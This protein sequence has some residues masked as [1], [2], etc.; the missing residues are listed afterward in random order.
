MARAVGS[1]ST[2]Q[3]F[4]SPILHSFSIYRAGIAVL[5]L[6]L[7]VAACRPAHERPVDLDEFEEHD[8][9]SYPR[10]FHIDTA[11][12]A[13]VER[14]G[15]P[16]SVEEIEISGTEANG[17]SDIRRIYHYDG[18]EFIFYQSARE[19]FHILAA[20]VINSDQYAIDIGLRVGMGL[21]VARDVLGEADF[22]QDESHV[23]SYG[24]SPSDR[25]NIELVVH[26]GIVTEIAVAPDLP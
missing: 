20:T 25:M 6:L 12:D 19:D 10:D 22:V 11:E 2:G 18:L 1:Q 7:V 9:F 15:D 21:G 3:G 26:D 13:V 5:L 23:F 14:F 17:E 24:S 8:I 4:E 16:D